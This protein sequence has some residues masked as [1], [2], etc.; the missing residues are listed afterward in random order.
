MYYRISVV[1][2]LY[3]LS[4]SAQA[5]VILSLE[6]DWG[7]S[8][9]IVDGGAGDVNPLDGA[10]TFVG[11]LG[12]FMLNVTTGLST[13][14]L[15]DPLHPILDLNS[16]DVSGGAGTITIGLSVTDF[17]G[18]VGDTPYSLAFGGTTNGSVDLALY[19]DSTNEAFG[20]QT[21]LAELG[22]NSGAFAYNIHGSASIDASPFSLTLLT[23][24][25]HYDGEWP[26]TT[27][28][29]AF[30]SVPEPGTLA[31]FGLGLLG[32]GLVR[33]KRAA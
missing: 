11:A 18:P 5:D 26:S 10:V 1:V 24:I 16:V 13:P 9:I 33:R 3:F 6:D 14:L 21:L 19:L 7:H 2:I 30:V 15:G 20:T 32:L 22:G 17:L 8:V 27:S 4:V 29:D 12:D 25:T 31:L 28:F 23:T